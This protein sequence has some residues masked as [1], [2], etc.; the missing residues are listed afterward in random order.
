MARG[1]ALQWV[2]G[3]IGGAKRREGEGW[4]VL[5]PAHD[6]H[7]PSCHVSQGRV[8]VVVNCY[9]GCDVEDIVRRWGFEMK[10]LF[11]DDRSG[12]RPRP[13]SKAVDERETVS[14]K[15]LARMFGQDEAWLR[16]KDGPVRLR[17]IGGA[18]GVP[19]LNEAGEE[20]FAR[21]RVT[22]TGRVK[23]I[24]PKG[25]KLQLYG[26]HRLSEYRKAKKLALMF[27]EGETDC[28]ALWRVGIFALGV[29]GASAV[30]TVKREHM[31]GVSM[32]FIFQEPGAAGEQFQLKLGEHL[33]SLGYRGTVKVVSLGAGRKDPAGL[34][35]LDPERF[36]GIFREAI[37]NA[38]D[39][40]SVSVDDLVVRMDTVAR[41][42]VSFLWEPYIPEGM[43]TIVGGKPGLGKSMWS[44]ALAAA[45]SAGLTFPGKEEPFEPGNVLMFSAEDDPEYVL[46][47]R[48]EDQGADL[49]RIFAFDLAR[50]SFQFGGA[51]FGKLQ[52]LI[53]R[54]E[55]KL[56]V[57]DP[58]VSFTGAR[59]NISR[60]NE[61]RGVLQPIVDVARKTGTSVVLIAHVGKGSSSNAAIDAI[62]GS[63]DFSAAPRSAMILY[64]DPSLAQG[65]EGGVIAHAKH[66]LSGGGQS[67]RYAINGNRFEW[68]GVTRMSAEDLQG[69]SST[70]SHEKTGIDEAVEFLERELDHGPVRASK[71]IFSARS[72]GINQTTLLRAR[73]RIG[74]KSKR[75][76]F[77]PGS[78]LQWNLQEGADPR[79]AEESEQEGESLPGEDGQEA[80]F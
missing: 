36:P 27:V 69:A 65:D 68:R 71:V 24:Q 79:D 8:G 5:C 46:R 20:V 41:R 14:V 45:I 31:E 21:R 2:L 4:M 49:S 7:N 61:V 73:M 12:S 10:D 35:A 16:D 72:H 76:G 25:S 34:F 48:L 60:Q 19:Y 6:D 40:S 15:S 51:D 22:L 39:W 62:M 23:Y 63:V 59:V 75:H 32:V 52:S 17:Q 33:L 54:F 64:P 78:Y 80:P 66:N 50:H 30:K 44:C 77:G 1:D 26:L 37:R 74:V 11:D 70:P 58:I 57:F 55:P 13:K 29:P 3:A 18:V 53:E 9:S 43:V 47:G 56:V 28:W 38:F 67:L 42:E